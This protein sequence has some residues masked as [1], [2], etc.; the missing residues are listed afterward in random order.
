MGV[1]DGVRRDV[2]KSHGTR[3]VEQD[4]YDRTYK[5]VFPKKHRK[6]LDEIVKVEAGE[7]LPDGEKLS[8]SQITEKAKKVAQLYI[9]TAPI[10]RFGSI[11]DAAMQW[12]QH[13]Q[14]EYRKEFSNKVLLTQ[15]HIRDMLRVKYMLPRFTFRTLAEDEQPNIQNDNFRERIKTGFMYKKWKITTYSW[16]G[17]EKDTRQFITEAYKSHG[18]RRWHHIP[19]I[20][21]HNADRAQRCRLYTKQEFVDLYG[22]TAE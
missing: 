11:C 21:I 3:C 22:G 2:A 15:L 1:F 6:D 12:E 4:E 20:P 13:K 8:N 7:Q 19:N 5:Y 10:H 9:D 18:L 14:N 16:N 17:G